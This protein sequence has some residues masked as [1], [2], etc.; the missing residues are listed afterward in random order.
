MKIGLIVNLNGTLMG[1]NFNS[2]TNITIGRE[3]DNII[4]PFAADGMSRH[5]AKIFAKD[6]K[7]FVE[8]L[9]STNGSYIMGQKIEAP[10]ELSVRDM[11][12][13]GKFEVSVDSISTDEAEKVAVQTITPAVAASAASAVP[14]AAAKPRDLCTK[15]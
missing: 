6:G 4:A 5:H 14:A 12:Q 10:Q 7:W 3:L 9:S 13:F 8:D 15:I 11:L 1:L 2:A